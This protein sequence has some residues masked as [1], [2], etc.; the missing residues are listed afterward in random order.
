M[1][2][3]QFKYITEE[4]KYRCKSHKIEMPDFES[5]DTEFKGI[6]FKVTKE[7]QIMN[8][9]DEMDKNDFMQENNIITILDYKPCVVKKK[10]NK[11]IEILS[12]FKDMISE[13]QNKEQI[14]F[15]FVAVATKMRKSIKKMSVDKQLNIILDALNVGY[16]AQ[17]QIVKDLLDYSRKID[18]DLSKLK[19]HE[20]RLNYLNS[21]NNMKQLSE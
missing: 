21:K 19:T 16:T 4:G 2:K 8:F 12:I 1:E 15:D 18:E 3:I 5:Y 10:I 14:Y 13:N 6:K 7:S 11:E 9:L 17:S 20:E